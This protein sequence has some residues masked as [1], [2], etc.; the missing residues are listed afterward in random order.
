MR[1]LATEPENYAAVSRRDAIRGSDKLLALL[2]AGI[3][4]N[5]KPPKG[6]APR[7]APKV[8][9]APR[10]AAGRKTRP[11]KYNRL[12]DVDAVEMVQRIQHAVADYFETTRADL[13]G[14][15]RFLRHAQ[16]RMVAVYLARN[17]TKFSEI[18]IG[19]QFGNRERTTVGHSVAEISARMLLDEQLAF[20]VAWLI[21]AITGEQQ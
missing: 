14:P 3:D 18:L 4:S 1:H 21:E 13:L 9:A 2:T 19:R 12:S 7:P 15:S 8:A 6:W 17:L 11:R 5:M 20:D 16:P 10:V